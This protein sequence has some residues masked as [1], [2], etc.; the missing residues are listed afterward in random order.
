[1]TRFLDRLEDL[2]YAAIHSASGLVLK[3][4]AAAIGASLLLVYF[5]GELIRS[6][7]I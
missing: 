2:I 3:I 5:G 6:F 1:M 7:A 4:S